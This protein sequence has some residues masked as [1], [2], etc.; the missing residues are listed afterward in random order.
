MKI[1]TIKRIINAT[2]KI[3]LI[4]G[5]RAHEGD[6]FRLIDDIINY[7]TNIK[8]YETTAIFEIETI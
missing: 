5:I 8:T 7:N 4:N 2:N 1:N 6:I 3:I